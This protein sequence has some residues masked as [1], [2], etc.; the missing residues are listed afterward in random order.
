MVLGVNFLM[1]DGMV[2]GD[3]VLAD[4]ARRVNDWM[5]DADGEGYYAE[6][7]GPAQD[8]LKLLVNSGVDGTVWKY[9]DDLLDYQWLGEEQVLGSN[10]YMPSWDLDEYAAAGTGKVHLTNPHNLSG[11]IWNLEGLT[12][13]E[14]VVIT[15]TNRQTVTLTNCDFKG[16]LVV[17]CPEEY[18]VRSGARNLVHVKKGTTIGGGSGGYGANVGLIAPGG[19]VKNEGDPNSLT[20]FSLVNEVD[21]LRNATVNGQFVILNDCK[22]LRECVFSYDPDVS[23]DLPPGFGYGDLLQHTE[24]LSV[25]EDFEE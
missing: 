4:K 23:E 3:M 19:R 5:F 15:L 6:S 20:G 14:T 25:F 17:L 1:S 11:A 8:G 13:E 9:R 24:V 7:H 21:L 12:Y 16:G 2:Y 10:V 18:D 22:D